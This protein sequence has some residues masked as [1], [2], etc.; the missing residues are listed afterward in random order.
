MDVAGG[1]AVQLSR[2]R[3]AGDRLRRPA[4]RRPRWQ[5]AGAEWIHLVDLD[6]AFGRGSQRRA[7]G[8]VIARLDV[9]VELS[10]GIRD[11]DAL[12]AA[13]AP[14]RSGSSS[15]PPHWSARTGFAR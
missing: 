1:Q 9:S 11:D 5:Q 6:A 8:R 2:A 14:V 7:A 13:L 3:P 4:G 15:A 12:A 10:G